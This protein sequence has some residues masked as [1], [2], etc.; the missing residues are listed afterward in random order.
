[1]I[2]ALGALIVFG[3]LAST[4]AWAQRTARRTAESFRQEPLAER[5][6]ST[7]ATAAS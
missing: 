4:G 3:A 2:F 7:E 1:V 6:V 5:Y